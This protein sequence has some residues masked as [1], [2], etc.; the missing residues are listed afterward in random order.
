MKAVVL[1]G[2]RENGG[3]LD[4]V[5]EIIVDEL[6]GMGWEV[7]PLILR[8]LEI[9]HCLGCFGCWLQTP[10]TCVIDDAGR[11]VARKYIQS[12]LAVLLTP[13]TFGG[14]SSELKKSIDRF[15]CPILAPFFTRIAGEVH[16]KPRYERYPRLMG[17]GLL[18]Q[19]DDEDEA[20]QI[21][22]TLVSRN[23][24]NLHAPAHA[25]GVALGDQGADEIRVEIQALLKA[26]E[27]KQ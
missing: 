11:D 5:R 27:V 26:V 13:V 12:D 3:A 4:G 22:A 2:S 19:A 15:A 1:D 18:P 17:V 16:H 14:Y 24:L 25:A 10:G 23:A 21:F 9:H 8:D 20:E 6:A 7:E